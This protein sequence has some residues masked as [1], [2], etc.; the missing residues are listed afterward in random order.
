MRIAK[1][2]KKKS[3][4][5]LLAMII[6]NKPIHHY[7]EIDDALIRLVPFIMPTGPDSSKVVDKNDA[8]YVACQSPNMHLP[9]IVRVS[10]HVKHKRQT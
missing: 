8:T 2:F 3:G 1:T 4:V 5:E 6:N 10:S 9:V 7:V